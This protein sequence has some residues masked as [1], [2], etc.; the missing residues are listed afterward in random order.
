MNKAAT[1][2]D[3]AMYAVGVENLCLA[4]RSLESLQVP[5]WLS[6]GT[7]LGFYRHRDLIPHDCDI[8]LGV[9]A[10]HCNEQVASILQQNGFSLEHRFGTPECGHEF[11]FRRNGVK[12]D[13]FAHYEDRDSIW[14]AVWSGPRMARYVL[15]RIDDVRYEFFCGE[16]FPIP[17]NGQ[18]LIIAQYGP[19]W[20]TPC[21]EWNYF[22]SPKNIEYF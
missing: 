12:L 6:C 1:F 15:P 16:V 9:M 10:A 7:L 2:K 19:D 21:E 22:R 3:P 4:K 14:M 18:Q 20:M 8:D 11:S 5:F 13:I 17:T